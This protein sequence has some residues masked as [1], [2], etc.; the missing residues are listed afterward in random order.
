VA[1]DHKAEIEQNANRIIE[2]IKAHGSEFE[3]EGID[4]DSLSGSTGL[5]GDQVT[6]AVDYL[7]NHEDVV[8]YP[9]GVTAPSRFLLKP[10][11]NWPSIREGAGA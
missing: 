2:W 7:E 11:R 9:Q 8:R 1:G 5:S 4:E 10:G 3:G 6:E